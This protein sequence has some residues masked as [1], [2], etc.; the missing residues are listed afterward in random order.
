MSIHSLCFAIAQHILPLPIVH[1]ISCTGTLFVFL[2]DYILNSI[3]ITSKQ[4]FGIVIG[5]FGALISTN[6]KVLT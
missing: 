4:A 5:V 3:K 1:T 6:G 2:F